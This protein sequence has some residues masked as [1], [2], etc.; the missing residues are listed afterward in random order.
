MTSLRGVIKRRPV[1]AYFALTFAI[2]WGGLLVVVG[3][4]GF[5]ATPEEF[6]RQL[7]IA[8][9]AMLGGPSIAGILL[10]GLVHGKAGLR[11]FLS[12][13]LTWHVSIRWYA[14]A[15]LTAPLLMLVILLPLSLVFPEFLPG[16]LT[17]D[18]WVSFLLLSVAIAVAAGIFEELGWTGFATPELRQRYGILATGLIVGSMWAVW[19]WLTGYWGSVAVA[20][21]LSLPVLLLDPILFLGVFRVLMV[22]VYDRT[23]SLFVVM[24]M[25]GSLTATARVIFPHGIGD[26]L[27][28]VDLLWLVVVLLITA[29]IYVANGGQLERREA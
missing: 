10:T 20:G 27:I 19:H 16:I 22:W 14:I 3:P 26:T 9:F 12:R 8:V 6:E 15:L 25:H 21:E 4:D 13:L 11:E 23:G 29:V 24:L 17:M 5:P 7:P 28:V 2:S 1:V 18:D